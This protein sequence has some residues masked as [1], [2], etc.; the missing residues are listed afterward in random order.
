MIAIIDYGIGNLRNVERA[1][2]HVGAPARLTDDPELVR[3]ADGVVVPGVG[4]FGACAVGLRR[5][6][7][8]ALVRETAA[9]GRPLLGICVGMQLLFDASEEMGQHAGLGLLPG[10]VLRFP[11]G[12]LDNTGHL[13]KV[14]QIGWNQ[15][16]HS[17]DDPLLRGVESGSYAYFV[18]SYY[19]AAANLS[20]VI[21]TTD[22]GID[23]ASVVRRGNIW[24]VQFHPEKSHA[25]G[26]QILRNFSEIVAA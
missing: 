16:W 15:L 12:G 7:F 10:R 13:L 24:G 23:Y 25:V 21:A 1:F 6:G 14:P 18:H 9:S 17:G 3:A 8:E 26:L 11:D 19:C 22:Y 4:A 5:G 2:Q 20:D